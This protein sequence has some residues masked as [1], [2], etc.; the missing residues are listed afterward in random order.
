MHRFRRSLLEEAARRTFE[1]VRGRPNL[2]ARLEGRDAPPL[3]LQGHVDVVTT[4]GQRWTH[5]PFEGRLVDG[6]VWGRGAL[7]MKGVAMLVDAF[8]RAKRRT[9]R[10]PATSSSSSSPTRRT[11]A[12]RARASSPKSIPSSSPA[13]AT[14]S[15][16][17]AARASDRREA[18]LS[19]PG[20]READL[21]AEGDGPR[22]GRPRR[23]RAP[24]RDRRAAR[25]LLRDLDRKRTP[26]HV[27]PVVREFVERIAAELPRKEA[28]V[29][30]S[31]LK[32]RLTDTALRLSATGPRRRSRCSGTPSTRR[33]SAAAR[34]STSSRARSSSSWTAGCCP[35][36]ERISPRYRRSSAGTSS[37]SSSA[38]IGPPGPD[39][40]LF[41]MLAGVL[42]ELDPNGIPVP[43][44]QIGVTDARFFGLVGIE[45]YGF[46]PMRMPD[47]FVGLQYIHAADERVPADALEF[48]AEAVFRASR[49]S[50]EIL[51]LGG[52]KFLGRA[53]VEAALARGHE[54]TLFNRGETNA[55]LFPARWRS[56][57]ATARAI[58]PRWRA[59][60]GRRRRSRRAT[61]RR[62]C[63]RRRS[64]CATPGCTSSSPAS[65]S[66]PTS[67]PGRTRRSVRRARRGFSRGSRRTSRT[68]AR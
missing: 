45:S 15:A 41:E 26:V 62:S 66:M 13:S 12:T 39:L 5:P 67:A 42:R 21:L 24:G 43:F 34:R 50:G 52:T 63:A 48:G 18:L 10:C 56:C 22:A 49:G 61:C 38:T 17:S 19:D 65:P 33:S 54:L 20:R 23:V 68:T 29:M 1:R 3:L 14:G 27:T 30:R 53:F 6:Y 60:L 40:G 32:P 64:C 57:A 59:Q 25:Q 7:D 2:V 8:L 16:S 31:L 51:V 11:A 58:S 44:L 9:S 4:S 55:D 37:S 35:A 46:L 28:T 36:R 47:D